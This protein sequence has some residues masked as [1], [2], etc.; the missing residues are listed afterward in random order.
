[1]SIYHSTFSFGVGKIIKFPFLNKYIYTYEIK[2]IELTKIKFSLIKLCKVLFD[3][4]AE[5]IYLINKEKTKVY[6]F[7]FK[8]IINNINDIKDLKLSSVH[9]LGK[10]EMGEK[11]Y[12]YTNSFG[13]IKNYDNI[14]I[15][16]SSLISTS[17]LQ[18]P[19]GTIMVLAYRNILKFIEVLKGKE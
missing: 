1:M 18:N 10:I 6:P 9:I 16:D 19:Q 12:C 11:D 13:K 15:N 3:G 4:G 8:K 7:D 14:F 2:N 5:Y 17:L